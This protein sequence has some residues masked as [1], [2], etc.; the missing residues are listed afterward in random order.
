MNQAIEDFMTVG[1]HTIARTR[2]LDEAHQ[3]MRENR[4]RHLPVLEGGKLVGIV[5]Q[6]DLSIVEGFRGVDPA[7]VPVEDAMSED[8]FATSPSA[9]IAEVARTMV[10]KRYGSAVVM[11]G[12]KVVGIFTAVDALRA[13]AVL[14][15]PQRSR[16]GRS[17]RVGDSRPDDL[18]G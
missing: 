2:T 7:T 1:V 3:L 13:L 5:T 18:W 6:R 8:V 16:R 11:R 14:T 4:I 10:Q 12:P 17:R 15:R 9:P